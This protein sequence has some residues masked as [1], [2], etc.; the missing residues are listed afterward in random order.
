M[1]T[2]SKGTLFKPELVT[3][4]INKVTGKSTL[5]KLS[6][7][8]PIPFN[9]IEQFVFN[10]DSEIDIVAE[11]GKKGPGGLTLE[12][13]SIVPLKVEYGARV[14]D[15]FIYASQEAQISILQAFNDGFA[16]KLAKGFDLM[17]IHGINPRTGSAS[18]II[19]TN[20]FDKK[21]TQTVELDEADPDLN[22]ESAIGVVQGA[23]GVVTGLGMDPQFATTLAKFK[24]N[25]VKQFPELSWG[26]NPDTIKGLKVD[27]NRTISNGGTNRVILGDFQSRFKW[28]YAKQIP[29]EI[30]RYG[31][32]DNTGQDLKGYNQVY[33]RAEAYIGWGIMQPEHFAIIKAGE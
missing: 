17:A 25:G 33:L 6:G 20:C 19:N 13:V 24:V 31:D 4:L 16:N 11:N 7:Q 8:T 30:I 22:V 12:P 29:M 26:A 18:D 28:G 10:M 5:A 3:D 2:L 9:G 32:P 21:V 15:E 1:G 14:S 27:V 23:D